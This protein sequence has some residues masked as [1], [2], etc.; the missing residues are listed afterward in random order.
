[1]PI[2]ILLAALAM[3][4]PS[5]HSIE[6]RWKSPGGNSII[7]IGPCAT[8]RCGTVAWASAKAKEDSRKATDQ[9]VGTELLTG[10][11]QDAKGRWHGKLFIPDKNMRVTA[12]LQLIGDQ[13]RVSGCAAGRAL[14]KSTLWSRVDGPLPISD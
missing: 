10:L 7:D 1:M 13:L 14:C 4:S 12:K 5:P 2:A 9:L 6:G 11:E 3:Q 8:G